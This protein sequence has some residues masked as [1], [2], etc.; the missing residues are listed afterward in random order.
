LLLGRS[1]PEATLG[2][3]HNAGTPTDFAERGSRGDLSWLSR[4]P[5]LGP[6]PASAPLPP[7]PLPPA[8]TAPPPLRP[9]RPW[10]PWAPGR[11]HLLLP[12]QRA[13]LAWFRQ[14]HLLL[15]QPAGQRP[16]RYC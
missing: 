12:G 1:G 13:T 2:N 11:G 4:R 3:S 7:T 10:S 5:F 14:I 16:Q 6:R 9:P 15:L 8:P